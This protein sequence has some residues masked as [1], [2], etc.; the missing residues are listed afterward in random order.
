MDVPV[1]VRSGT[2]VG[3]IQVDGA[4]LQSC[5]LEGQMLSVLAIRCVRL[6]AA[7]AIGGTHKPPSAVP[8]QLQCRAANEAT[9]A[10]RKC[11]HLTPQTQREEI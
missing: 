11:T 9:F 5:L 4:S 10:T 6:E 8:S 1:V 7:G 3:A 2:T